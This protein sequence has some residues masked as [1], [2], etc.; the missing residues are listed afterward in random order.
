MSKKSG[1]RSPNPKQ[2]PIT[3]KGRAAINPRARHAQTT[4][5]SKHPSKVRQKRIM[6]LV[7]KLGQTLSLIDHS[8]KRYGLGAAILLSERQ[9]T[10]QRLELAS[11][12]QFRVMPGE[13]PKTQFLSLAEPSEVARLANGLA[14]A[15]R[16][17]ILVAVHTGAITHQQLSEKLGLK[18]GPL[19]H[20]IR[21]LERAG[22]MK[23]TER[24]RL[25]L[26]ENG[27]RS[28]LVLS[29]LSVASRE[30]QQGW[31]VVGK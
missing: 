30:S 7:N 17:R 2:G 28:L 1:T 10:D 25:A 8:K 26:T 20:H 18:T 5:R 21:A 9:G 24:N 27:R 16:I 15:D 13:K 31:R 12:A 23:F 11:M 14:H 3:S 6:A 22:V 19:Y 29:L 4:A